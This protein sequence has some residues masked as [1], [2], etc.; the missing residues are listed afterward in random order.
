[1]VAQTCNCDRD[2]RG[3]EH[4][5]E[6]GGSSIRQSELAFRR[7]RD[8]FTHIIHSH[9]SRQSRNTVNPANQLGLKSYVKSPLHPSTSLYIDSTAGD[10]RLIKTR[11]RKS[12]PPWV[13]LPHGAQETHPAWQ[14]RS[15]RRQSGKQKLQSLKLYG[16]ATNEL[17]PWIDQ[18]PNLTKLHPHHKLGHP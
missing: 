9:S 17:P 6:I 13:G 1:M 4:C 7:L 5:L 8:V 11:L 3:G 15:V 16:L 10:G 18:L 12:T 14:A 2:G